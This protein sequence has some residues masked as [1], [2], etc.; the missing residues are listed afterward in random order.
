MLLSFIQ[1]LYHVDFDLLSFG[2][3][4]DLKTTVQEM[5]IH[6]RQAKELNKEGYKP[7]TVLSIKPL[8]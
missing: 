5:L 8:R 2:Q 3:R 6:I 7:D 4:Q 1:D